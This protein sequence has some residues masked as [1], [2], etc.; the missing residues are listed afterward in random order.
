MNLCEVV[1]GQRQVV[2]ESAGIRAQLKCSTIRSAQ[3]EG[4]RR[5]REEREGGEGGRRRVIY[6]TS[7]HERNKGI[8]MKEIRAY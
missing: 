2:P 5:G 8:H 3:G 7:I 4:G 6:Y 1:V